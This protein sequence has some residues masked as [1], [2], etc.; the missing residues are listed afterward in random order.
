MEGELGGARQDEGAV[1]TCD[2]VDWYEGHRCILDA[3]HA[4]H[5]LDEWGATWD[6]GASERSLYRVHGQW[7]PE[8]GHVLSKYLATP[9]EPCARLTDQRLSG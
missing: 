1:N 4:G 9:P 6:R 7:W 5:H 8:R 2:S 3:D